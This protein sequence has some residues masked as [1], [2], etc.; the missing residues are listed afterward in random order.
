[1]V[2]RLLKTIDGKKLQLHPNCLYLSWTNEGP[3]PQYQATWCSYRTIDLSKNKFS[4]YV[5]WK[6]YNNDIMIATDYVGDP[7]SVKMT[8][9]Y[10]NK[11]YLKSHLQKVIRRSNTPRALKT[12]WH[13]LDL[14]LQDFL[15]RIAIIAIEDCL[16]LDGYANIIWFMAAVSKGYVLSN[17]QICWILGYVYDLSQCTNYE[18]IV[19]DN[20]LTV[21]T[22]KSRSLSQEGKNLVYSILFRKSY[23]GMKGDKEMCL[24]AAQLWSSRFGT[25]SLFLALLNR[26]L[27]FITPPLVIMQKSEWII[28]AI[29]FH[30]CQ[31]IVSTMWEKHDEFSE[32]DIRSAIWHCSSSVTNKINIGPDREQRTPQKYIEIWKVI[33]KDFLSYAKFVLDKNG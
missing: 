12:A 23:G 6:D 31:G 24:A 16:P 19:H 13:F 28:G 26:P 27:K 20:K 21:K 2:E 33:K 3:T 7:Y 30:C 29:D 8:N 4:A 32:D 17:E 5:K 25:Q 14:D 15:R 11:E 10:R 1:M 9:N 22:I 18:Q